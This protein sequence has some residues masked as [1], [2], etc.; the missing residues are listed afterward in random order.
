[1]RRARGPGTR[2]GAISYLPPAWVPAV[3]SLASLY[4]A[5]VSLLAPQPRAAR[6]GRSLA[7]L[8]VA[9]RTSLGLCPPDDPP[10]SAPARGRRPPS[11]GGRYTARACS[12]QVEVG[13]AL[14]VCLVFF[15]SLFFVFAFGFFSL[16]LVLLFAVFFLVTG[17]TLDFFIKHPRRGSD[18]RDEG[19]TRTTRTLARKDKG[20]KQSWE[21]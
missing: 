14:F 2:S 20:R 19:R 11:L 13:S 10:A 9:P 1:M 21:D 12:L 5:P 8:S 17:E 16:F 15:P 4:L 18:G 3:S 7:R 6:G